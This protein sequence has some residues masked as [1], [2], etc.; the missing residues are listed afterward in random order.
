MHIVFGLVFL[1]IAIAMLVIGRPPKGE[2]A[3][4]FLDVWIVGQLYAMITLISG[5][6]GVAMLLTYFGG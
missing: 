4:R 1:A 2:D 6:I 5:V 3:A